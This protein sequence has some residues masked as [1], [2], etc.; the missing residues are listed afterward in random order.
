MEYH[1]VRYKVEKKA[2]HVMCR[3]LRDGLLD[4]KKSP[5]SCTIIKSWKKGA[6]KDINSHKNILILSADKGNSIVIMDKK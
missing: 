1:S 3:C 5:Y 4:R 6:L 2:K